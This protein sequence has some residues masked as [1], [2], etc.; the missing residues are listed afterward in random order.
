MR[1]SFNSGSGW[2]MPPLPPGPVTTGE[3]VERARRRLAH[4]L[5]ITMSPTSDE[6]EAEHDDA[7]TEDG[8]L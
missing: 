7:D 6:S 1:M 4:D 2:A 3:D 5:G 8:T